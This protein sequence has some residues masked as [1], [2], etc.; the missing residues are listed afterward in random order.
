MDSTLLHLSI[1]G[2]VLSAYIAMDR[3]HPWVVPSSEDSS[4]P[5]EVLRQIVWTVTGRNL[6]GLLPEVGM[7]I[8]CY[9]GPL[10]DSD[11]CVKTACMSCTWW[12]AVISL[13]SRD[14]PIIRLKTSP[15]PTGRT[16]QGSSKGGGSS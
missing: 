14:L 16:L 10:H 1:K 8:G 6:R 13:L 2:T 7:C 3:G 12:P 9:G 4:I 5:P 15:I 11:D